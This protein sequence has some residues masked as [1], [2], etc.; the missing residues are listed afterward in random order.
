MKPFSIL[1]YTLF[2]YL[3]FSLFPINSVAQELTYHDKEK[4]N[5]RIESIIETTKS[6]E[7][8]YLILPILYYSDY[9]ENKYDREGNLIERIGGLN[10]VLGLEHVL[11]KY[12][13]RGNKILRKSYYEGSKDTIYSIFKYDLN[14]NLIFDS[15]YLDTRIYKNDDKGR[16]IEIKTN[17]FNTKT[18]IAYNKEDKIDS[19]I[20]YS[21]GKI[22]SIRKFKY[23][24]DTNKTIESVYTNDL[25][26]N[27]ILS[28]EIKIYQRDTILIEQIKYEYNEEGKEIGVEISKYDSKRRLI[29]FAYLSETI[30]GTCKYIYKYNDKDELIEVISYFKNDS[31]AGIDKFKY[32]Y[33]R[34]GNWIKKKIYDKS[35]YT[36]VK[37]KIKYY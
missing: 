26:Y 9:L 29:Y 8:K 24:R 4:L 22:S 12:D 30:A 10:N 5:G 3:A 13:E 16:M 37:R 1:I 20:N 31:L 21:N 14:N 33:D 17:L 6:R 19:V 7:W 23:L 2:I 36:I 25:L 27:Q 35:G 34:K 28:K 11:Y 18:E 32:K 15:N